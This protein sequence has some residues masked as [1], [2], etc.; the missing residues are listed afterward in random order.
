MK[1]RGM[2]RMKE[3]GETYLKL[4]KCQRSFVKKRICLLAL[5]KWPRILIASALGINKRT[6]EGVID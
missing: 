1:L 4:S 6:V 2:S 5:A 3:I